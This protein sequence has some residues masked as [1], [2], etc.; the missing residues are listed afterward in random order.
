MLRIALVAGLTGILCVANSVPV[1]A[2]PWQSDA[3]F[4]FR[5]TDAPGKAYR[6]L[7]KDH[8]QY[9]S[10]LACEQAAGDENASYRIRQA[11]RDRVNA[12][13]MGFGSIEGCQ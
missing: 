6:A 1:A 3:K 2:Q 11:G 5:D 9:D 12:F 10:I 4:C 7:C 8:D 13:M